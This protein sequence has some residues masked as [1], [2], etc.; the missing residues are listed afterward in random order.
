MKMVTTT[1]VREFLSLKVMIKMEMS[2][3]I[4]MMIWLMSFKTY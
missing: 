3:Q 2:I 1:T 4:E